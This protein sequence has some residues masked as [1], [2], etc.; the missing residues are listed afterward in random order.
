MNTPEELKDTKRSEFKSDDNISKLKRRMYSREHKGFLPWRNRREVDTETPLANREWKYDN[1]ENKDKIVKLRKSKVG[2]HKRVGMFMIFSIAFF[3]LAG[4]GSF[5]HL[6]QATDTAFTEGVDIVIEGKKF[7]KS[8]DVLEMQ[9]IITNR[10]EVPILLADI[11]VT[12]PKGTVS[13]V[14]Y[15][16]SLETE[17]I[18]I[19]R[20]DARKAHRG[21]SLR[22]VIFGNAGDTK[23]IQ[24]ELQYRFQGSN[25]IHSKSVKHLIIISSNAMSI[26]V[27]ANTELTPG[28]DIPIGISIKSHSPNVLNGV[29]IDVDLPLGFSITGSSPEVQK[30][31]GNTDDSLR[32]YIGT[33]HPGESRRV[34]MSGK[35]DGQIGD[36]RILNTSTGVG[37]S[38]NVSKEDEEY[39]VLAKSR[40]TIEVS[41]S[42]LEVTLHSRGKSLGSNVAKTQESMDITLRWRN[43]LDVPINDAIIAIDLGGLALN[44]AG[45]FAGADGFYRSVDSQLVWSAN[46]SGGKLKTIAPKETGEF[47]FRIVPIANSELIN[48]IEPTI[49][50]DIHAGG[51]RLSEQGVPEVL[52]SDSHIELKIATDSKFT[53]KG[54]FRSSKLNP[55]GPLP[56]MSEYKTVYGIVWEVSNT[57]NDISNSIVTAELP[58]YVKWMG[59]TSP[60]NEQIRYNK[61]RNTIEW[62]LGNVHA[63][64]G[65]GNTKTRKVSFAVG[66]VPSYAQIGSSP[67]LVQ[68]QV[69][70]AI[71]T[72]TKEEIE[73]RVVNIDTR[74]IH[75][76]GYRGEYSRVIKAP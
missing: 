35:I 29:Y 31:I 56:P 25:V 76:A 51:R 7:I 13:P 43:N 15:K 67:D 71:D 60:A 6:H 72:F 24:V 17:R 45:V 26:S 53:S 52:R 70:R 36:V 19:G 75:D 4:I 10:K 61:V 39:I 11:I 2:T 65:V 49:T 40:H 50:F 21:G 57:T 3:V 42:F 44:K 28:Q 41:R 20:L 46:T 32:W 47:K 58:H 54:L 55:R 22:A 37:A 18:S 8:G 59:L 14:D 38:R 16:T 74:I 34:Y 69:F 27:D 64:T 62:H 66:L 33:L 30:G 68:N 23:E 63:G 5:F 9:V 48:I 12:Y 1:N 73:Q